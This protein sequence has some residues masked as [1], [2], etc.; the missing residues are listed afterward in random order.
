MRTKTHYAT[1]LALQGELSE[2]SEHLRIADNFARQTVGKCWARR[3]VACWLC[4]V[5]AICLSYEWSHEPFN[6]AGSSRKQSSK[7]VDERV[8][9]YWQKPRAFYVSSRD[10]DFKFFCPTKNAYLQAKF[11]KY[12]MPTNV[13]QDEQRGKKQGAATSVDAQKRRTEVRGVSTTNK[14]VGRWSKGNLITFPTQSELIYV[15]L[16]SEQ[17]RRNLQLQKLKAAAMST[18]GKMTSRKAAAL[19]K[20]RVLKTENL[21][22]NKSN[23]RGAQS[24]HARRLRASA[25]KDGNKKTFSLVLRLV[26]VHLVVVA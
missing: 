2:H 22:D 19:S 17:R 14:Y 16:Y 26:N 3:W 10:K 12:L 11:C 21:K 13:V 8:E 18:G 1:Q 7:N 20:Q 5:G 25:G 6:L 9:P 15:P 24:I 4:L 23:P